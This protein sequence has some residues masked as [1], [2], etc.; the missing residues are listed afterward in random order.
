MSVH[1]L[2]D[3]PTTNVLSRACWASTQIGWLPATH[4]SANRHGTPII[5]LPRWSAGHRCQPQI[6]GC[7]NQPWIR[8]L[9][10]V[11][12]NKQLEGKTDKDGQLTGRYSK[13]I[14]S[15][16]TPHSV[17]HSTL[18]SSNTCMLHCTFGCKLAKHI[19]TATRT[20]SVL[21]LS[22][23]CLSVLCA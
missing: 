23:V 6:N 22:L 4:T 21:P 9:E 7:N 1:T 3:Q 12:V 18:L 14:H 8:N 19:R 20:W 5:V 13:Y 11:G 17:T 10:R 2:H 15:S 16:S